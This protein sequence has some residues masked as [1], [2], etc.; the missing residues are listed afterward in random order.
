MK[1]LCWLVPARAGRPCWLSGWPLRPRKQ[2]GTDCA[3]EEPAACAFERGHS[4]LLSYEMAPKRADQ[5]A[6]NMGAKEKDV[7]LIPDPAPIYGQSPQTRRWMP[8]DAWAPTWKAIR[9]ANPV[10][11]IADTGPKAMGGE[12]DRSRSRNR[13]YTSTGTRS[14]A[15]RFRRVSVGP[16]YETCARRRA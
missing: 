11:V 4:V 6:E 2:N 12:T 16:R 10:L 13:V 1:S 5:Y 3:T 8:S 9:N 15:G 7:L 14:S